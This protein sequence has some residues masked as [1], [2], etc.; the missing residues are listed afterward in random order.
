MLELRPPYK[1]GHAPLFMRFLST[2]ILCLLLIGTAYSSYS[3]LAFEELHKELG[4]A[5]EAVLEKA[6]YLY[7][8][9]S[10]N[11]DI[12][13]RLGALLLIALSQR[14][15]DEQKAY[16]NTLQ[17]GLSLAKANKNLAYQGNFSYLIA[18]SL[19]YQGNYSEALKLSDQAVSLAKSSADQRIYADTL[20]S[21][22]AIQLDLHHHEAALKDMLQANLLYKSNKD[23]LEI[24]Y[25]LS[26]IAL[27]Y[28]AT[29]DYKK[30]IRYLLESADYADKSDLNDATLLHLNLGVT[31]FRNQQF[32]EAEE[33]LEK[34]QELAVTSNSK[35]N[36]AQTS[37]RLGLLRREQKRLHEGIVLL[38]ESLPLFI[39]Q[40]DVMMQF[41]TR[42]TLA[43]L[44]MAT[45]DLSDESVDIQSAERH[46][47]L[48]EKL[49]D[50]L[51]IPQA[52][53]SLLQTQADSYKI[54][55]DYRKVSDIL[56]KKI[57]LLNSIHQ[58]EK[59]S[60]LE[61]LKLQFH[62]EQEEKQNQLLKQNNKLQ[63][64]TISEQ[65]LRQW[66]QYAVI[67]LL[68]GLLWL[69]GNNMLKHRRLGK[70]MTSLALFDE[71]TGAPNRRSVLQR[72]EEEID[73]ANRHR[74]P[75][76][77][78]LIDMDYFKKINDT[79]GHQAGDEVL[80]LFSKICKQSIRQNDL[81]GRYGGEEWLIICPHT[82]QQEACIIIDRMQKELAQSRIP[83]LPDDYQITF[84][85]GVCQNHAS[86]TELDK[87]IQRADAALY[88]AKSEGRNRT[89]LYT[90]KQQRI[91]EPVRE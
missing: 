3:T 23:K 72:G 41:N 58:Q 90:R 25:M 15:M 83:G 70:Q 12:D 77:V 32:E 10:T 6:T 69:I 65:K 79:F 54:K 17:Q 34:A 11:N 88:Q 53:L 28:S 8:M 82:K 44:Y 67:L 47:K 57:I 73:R 24:G 29:G 27:V 26:N 21:R 55:N 36:I 31:Y 48:A 46:L 35:I 49:S 62:R 56:E 64:E 75:L 84:S 1:T 5:P 13:E 76:T 18:E 42:I 74:M 19:S 50:T 52:Q 63:A 51:K 22:G 68:L 78:V 9:A 33:Q 45:S 61:R 2:F 85:A 60:K 16:E 38:K 40:Q 66:L 91:T 39:L 71:L 89:I 20:A 81:F 86:E 43:K 87:L 37:F 80:I 7:D 14:L 4:R 30:A 59:N